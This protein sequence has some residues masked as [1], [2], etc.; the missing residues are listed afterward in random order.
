MLTV[1]PSNESLT[2]NQ[3]LNSKPDSKQ[4]LYTENT[5]PALDS[6]PRGSKE[7]FHAETSDTLKMERKDHEDNEN[8]DNGI[9]N[10]LS[11][12][13][14]IRKFLDHPLLTACLVLGSVVSAGTDFVKIPDLLKQ[15]VDKDSVVLIKAAMMTRYL[16][17]AVEAFKENRVVES[18][19]RLMGIAALPLVKLNDLTLA[20]GLGEFI[21]QLDLALEGKIKQRRA[22]NISD[23]PETKYENLKMWFSSL[24]EA[25]KEIF[26]G[27]LGENR[28]LFPTGKDEGHTLVMAGTLTF[29]GSA[30]GMLLGAKSRDLANKVFGSVRSLGGL[31]ADYTLLTHP[32][33]NMRKAGIVTTL[34]SI[35]DGIQRFLP[36]KTLNTINH[37]N[38]LNGMFANQ[39]LTNRTHSKSE[40]DI[41][42]YDG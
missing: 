9:G 1:S 10:Q 42:V 26:S 37:L 39:L 20:T 22:L 33:S 6:T 40:N 14:L 11:K 15:A 7:E 4:P 16:E 23:K 5:R 28:K 12:P 38:L 13:N 8:A 17:T 41:K 32:D 25:Y 36:E 3:A 30:L 27:G 29:L 2:T 21:P 19:G 35:V 18:A 34:G 24:G 31:I